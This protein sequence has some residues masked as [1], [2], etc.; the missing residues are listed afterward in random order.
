MME[1][2]SSVTLSKTVPFEGKGVT[3]SSLVF[4]SPSAGHKISTKRKAPDCE[5]Q[6]QGQARA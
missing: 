1:W 3:R 4:L 2:Q 6:Q 5:R